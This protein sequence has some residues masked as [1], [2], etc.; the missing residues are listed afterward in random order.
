MI[1]IW[2]C[3]LFVFTNQNNIYT[4]DHIFHY[5]GRP[6]PPALPGAG[7]ST[8]P[9]YEQTT[10]MII[11]EKQHDKKNLSDNCNDA[12]N[13]HSTFYPIMLL[14]KST[15]WNAWMI[16]M[17]NGEIIYCVCAAKQFKNTWLK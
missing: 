12:I 10:G 8:D 1:K 17:S 3:F 9:T 5:F 2:I 15:E 16:P 6:V 11:V 4:V 7:T 13:M 14:C